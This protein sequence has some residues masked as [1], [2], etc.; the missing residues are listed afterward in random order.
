MP[1]QV[2]PLT[3]NTNGTLGGARSPGWHVFYVSPCCARVDLVGLRLDSTGPMVF[4]ESVRV[5]GICRP[6]QR[7]AVFDHI[8][9]TIA[10]SCRGGNTRAECSLPSGTMKPL[11]AIKHAS[12]ENRDR[13]VGKKS[14]GLDRRILG[15]QLKFVDRIS[16]LYEI[17]L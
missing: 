15:L 1:R 11:L 4:A 10:W 17:C 16:C 12:Y 13:S 6:N 14:T 3:F 8:G 2:L 5:Q 9:L 7:S